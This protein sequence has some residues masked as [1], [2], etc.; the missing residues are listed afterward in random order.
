MPS[1]VVRLSRNR[2]TGRS[3]QCKSAKYLE[4][5]IS[6]KG[7]PFGYFAY[8]YNSHRN[9]NQGSHFEM[10]F[11]TLK[12]GQMAGFQSPV[13]QCVFGTKSTIVVNKPFALLIDDQLHPV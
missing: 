4:K 1:G 3:T 8:G 12:P 13:M 11:R 9:I 7:G 6:E 10:D 5:R 2:L